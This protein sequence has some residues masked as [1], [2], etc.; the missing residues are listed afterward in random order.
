MPDPDRTDHYDAQL[1]II[2]LVSQGY[3]GRSG[4]EQAVATLDTLEMCD[5]NELIGENPNHDLRTM[6]RFCCTLVGAHHDDDE[7]PEVVRTMIGNPGIDVDIA[8]EI[9]EGAEAGETP[10]W[11]LRRAAMMLRTGHTYTETSRQVPLPRALVAKVSKFIDAAGAQHEQ[12]RNAA[13]RVAARGGDV[14]DMVAEASCSERVA[15]SYMRQTWDTI[16]SMRDDH[17]EL[18]AAACS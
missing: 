8:R 14:G 18:E 9:V 4:L 17:G 13:I 15:A 3:V 2:S 5:P 12:L 10:G 7:L 16:T 1:R 6:I 11:K